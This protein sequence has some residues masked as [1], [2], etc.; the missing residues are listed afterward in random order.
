MQL[1][2]RT[3]AA[4]RA[5]CSPSTTGWGLS[6]VAHACAGMLCY[7]LPGE[8][9]RPQAARRPTAP[10]EVSVAFV[11]PR[12][13]LEPMDARPPKLDAPT[14]ELPETTV[15]VK[16]I[17]F[18]EP[19]QAAPEP[20]QPRVRECRQV[21]PLD[22][23]P[24]FL[25]DVTP[26]PPPTPAPLPPAPTQPPAPVPAPVQEA[27]PSESP[28]PTPSQASAAVLSPVPD[29]RNLPPSY[30]RLARRRGY[31]GT[32]LLR[33]RVSAEG[34]CLAVEVV[35]SSGYASLDR[36]AVEAVQKWEFE[37]ARSDG[38]AVEAV[39]EAPFRFRLTE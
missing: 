1:T 27:R 34:R 12:P 36:A 38:V 17:E 30:P 22:A 28:P 21:E 13:Q 25:T 9:L 18:T 8:S 6:L 7:F 39:V 33:V 35:T 20:R 24:V 16:P 19:E 5:A 23:P 11:E 31:E 14:V 26:P 29:A 37:P 10:V 32:V 4:T 15:P 3:S 2:G